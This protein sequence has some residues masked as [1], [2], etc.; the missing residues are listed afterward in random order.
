M[1]WKNILASGFTGELLNVLCGNR[2]KKNNA[3][4]QEETRGT[5]LNGNSAL[6]EHYE[7]L[8][9]RALGQQSSGVIWGLVVL[10]TKGMASWE[11][12]W[13]ECAAGGIAHM[14]QKEAAP[15][16]SCLHLPVRR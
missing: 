13:L 10:R 6:T 7:D 3:S 5:S 16:A 8:R 1:K 9:Q 2:K 15:S 4:C 12:V 11:R 14:P